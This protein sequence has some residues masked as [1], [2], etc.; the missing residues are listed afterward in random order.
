M[1]SAPGLGGICLCIH[2]Y[3]YIR[4]EKRTM[5][6]GN[7]LASAPG[8]DPF[9][10]QERTNQ[11]LLLPFRA[12]PPSLDHQSGGTRTH[13]QGAP[14]G[15]YTSKHQ[16]EQSES[17]S[18]QLA[19]PLNH[20]ESGTG[21]ESTATPTRIVQSS[22]PVSSGRTSAREGAALPGA[23]CHLVLAARPRTPIKVTRSWRKCDRQQVAVGAGSKIAPRDPFCSGFGP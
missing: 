1:N 22:Q 7:P 10:Q 16:E 6:N 19:D 21:G 12:S 14:V 20:H 9:I 2:A 17:P 5:P 4:L 15:I 23:P 8:E 3:T 18:P 11:H 13:N